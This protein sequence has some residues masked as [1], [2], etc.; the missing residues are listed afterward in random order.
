MEKWFLSETQPQKKNSLIFLV[1][2]VFCGKMAASSKRSSAFRNPDKQGELTKRGLIVKSW[3]IRWFVLQGSRLYYYSSRE[4]DIPLG[5]LYLRECEVRKTSIDN[6]QN[7][8]ELITPND[9]RGRLIAFAK[10]EI[11]MDEWSEA[12]LA[13]GKISAV[14]SAPKSV[15]HA[16][17][18][19][20]TGEGTLNGVPNEWISMLK[21]AGIL[22]IC[23][24]LKVPHR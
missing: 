15:K 6:K 7:C 12:L 18:V 17:H 24:L 21:A 2:F 10:D 3:K 1:S 9:E 19:S 20:Q 4:S 13:A 22:F 23:F 14:C 11:E 16:V 8:F 5:D